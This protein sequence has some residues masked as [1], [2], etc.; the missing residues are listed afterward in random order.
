MAIWG[1]SP[2]PNRPI[3]SKLCSTKNHPLVQNWPRKTL[4][5]SQSKSGTWDLAKGTTGL[6]TQQQNQP[7]WDLGN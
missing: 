5:I 1:V 2:F 3:C 4:S 7:C 6:F